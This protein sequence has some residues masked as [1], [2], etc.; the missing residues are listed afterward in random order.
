MMIFSTTFVNGKRKVSIV[1]PNSN[2]E[3][4]KELIKK[5]FLPIINSNIQLN[6]EN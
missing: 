4:K 6:N 3:L 2:K 5:E 1:R